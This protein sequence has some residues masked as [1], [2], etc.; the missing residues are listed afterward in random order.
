MNTSISDVQSLAALRRRSGATEGEFLELLFKELDA[1]PVPYCV[2]RNY[3]SLPQ[4]TGG[5]DLDLLVPRRCGADAGAVI[6]RVVARTKAAVV[7]SYLSA[8]FLKVFL[9]GSGTDGPWGL[10]LDVNLGLSFKGISCIANDQVEALTQLHRGVR[11]LRGDVAAVLGVL[12][13]LLNHGS[14]SERY[15]LVAK[16]TTNREWLDIQELLEP[17]GAV[18]VAVLKDALASDG[19]GSRVARLLRH[20]L[21][22]RGIFKKPWCYVRRRT[23]HE[24]S[25]LRRWLM[26]PGAMVAVLGVDGVGKSTVIAGIEP[27]LQAATHGA[28]RISHLRPAL[29]PP[30]A[31][32]K[33]A[34]TSAPAVP[35]VEPHGSTPSGLIGSLLRIVYYTSDYIAGYW[36]KV[37]PAIAREPTVWLFDRY[38]YDIVFDPRRFRISLPPAVTKAFV[39]TIPR[40]DLIL[41]LHADP[42]V[43][44][45]R[46]Q[47][48]PPDEIQRQ[49]RALRGFAAREPRAVL[50]STEGTPTE[51][52]DRVLDTVREF[53][54]RRAALRRLG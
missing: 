20:R 15:R 48:L 39:R 42:G 2:M 31:R 23:S 3:E 47:E 43:I 52:R 29:L 38:A 41:C 10:R 34:A 18:A 7:G 27:A 44:G 30:L 24:V 54:A 32:L 26:P 33:G 4:T 37:R 51:V 45:A 40:P 14:M 8:E 22:S 9:L 16:A 50:I 6:G 36:L 53:F 11:V 5:S 28:L 35:V 12:K 17:F 49:V 13:E 19:G 25:K 46:K 1:A 21:L